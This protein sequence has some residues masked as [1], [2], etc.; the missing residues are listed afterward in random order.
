MPAEIVLP[1]RRGRLR[2]V[3]RRAV[4]ERPGPAKVQLDKA[5]PPT[6]R[7][8]GKTAG[9]QVR[10]WRRFRIGFCSC[11]LAQTL[12]A[13]GRARSVGGGRRGAGDGLV[14]FGQRARLVLPAL[15]AGGPWQYAADGSQMRTS[16]SRSAVA[17]AP[18]GNRARPRWAT[19]P[20]KLRAGP[21]ERHVPVADQPRCPA[22]SVTALGA[23]DHMAA[24]GLERQASDLVVV[25]L[26]LVHCAF[27]VE[28]PVDQAAVGAAETACRL[29]AVT[30]TSQTRSEWPMRDRSGSLVIVSPR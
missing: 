27:R 1:T 10:A 24:V 19:P 30:A 20:A 14:V 5:R 16:P 6:S 29:S 2:R 25:Q 13:A 23:E 8:R 7:R 22:V 4:L 17:T 26:D 11:G 18:C 15:R 28:V 9:H 12:R 3:R 21:S